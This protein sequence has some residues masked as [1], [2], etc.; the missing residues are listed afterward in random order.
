[1]L[2]ELEPI[3]SR[4]DQFSFLVKLSDVDD[5]QELGVVV[6]VLLT[7]VEWR[8]REPTLLLL[9]QH[10]P[11]RNTQWRGTQWSAPVHQHF[12]R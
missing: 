10:F 3:V 9:S 6:V 12:L 11:M 7:G 4:L 8:V 2:W 1:M 5:R